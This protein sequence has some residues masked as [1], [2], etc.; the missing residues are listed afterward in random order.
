MNKILLDTHTLIWYVG[1]NEINRQARKM[2]DTAIQENR[3]YLAAISLWEINML[4]MKQRIILEMPGFEW[5]NRAIRELHLQIAPLTPAIA[6]ESCNLPESFHGDPADRMIV[7][8][9]RVEG[10]TLVTRDANILAY[11]KTRLL[12]VIKA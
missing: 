1:G 11:G 2:I 12:S 4:L 7:G 10:M 8:T 5:V 3:I 6:V 9:A